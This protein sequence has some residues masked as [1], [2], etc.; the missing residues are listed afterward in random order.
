MVIIHLS[1]GVL[2]GINEFAKGNRGR[3]R[4]KK[5]SEDIIYIL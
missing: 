2:P 4:K 3:K 5:K 1:G